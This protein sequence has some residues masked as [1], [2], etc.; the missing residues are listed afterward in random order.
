MKTEQQI[1][2]QL[3]HYL[4]RFDAVMASYNKDHNETDEA[5]LRR[6]QGRID[7]LRWV[8]GDE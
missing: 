5:M 8:L 7:T 2:D 4:K 1:R 3:A 6:L